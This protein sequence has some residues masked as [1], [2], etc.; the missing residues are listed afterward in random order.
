MGA[1][2]LAATYQHVTGAAANALMPGAELQLLS[3]IAGVDKVLAL[4][5][6]AGGSGVETAVS[7]RRRAAPKLRH[8]GRVLTLADVE[9]FTASRFPLVAQNQGGARAGR[10]AAGRGVAGRGSAT[11]AGVPA[12]TGDEAGRGGGLWT[13]APRRTPRGGTAAAAGQRHRRHRAG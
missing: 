9:D 2:L 3:P 6:A 11:G 7:A 4:G 10:R 13:G 1:E 8:G 5:L 12:R